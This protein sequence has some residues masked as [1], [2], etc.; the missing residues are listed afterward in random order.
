MEE[1][2]MSS[3]S[4]V[5]LRKME[6]VSWSRIGIFQV[7]CGR[8]SVTALLVLVVAIEELEMGFMNCRRLILRWYCCPEL[9]W[10]VCFAVRIELGAVCAQLQARLIMAAAT[11]LRVQV[12]LKL[13]VMFEA[14]S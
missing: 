1:S 6:M 9:R 12:L 11:K 4:G 10:D 5:D 7:V 2:K 8:S 14:A 3:E 13:M